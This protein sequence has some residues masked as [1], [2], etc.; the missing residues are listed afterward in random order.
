VRDRL[1]AGEIRVHPLPAGETAR[2]V[3]EP[4]R[5]MDLGAGRGRSVEA[6]LTGGA[7]GVVLD[8]RGRPLDLPADDGR[9]IAALKRWAAS[10][11]LY[12][13]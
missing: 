2:A 9:R 5:G 4:A 1:A 13:E 7:V 12:P 10:L 8:A 11:S 6:D 3:L